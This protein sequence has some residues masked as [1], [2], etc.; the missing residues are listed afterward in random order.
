MTRKLWVGWAC[1]V[2]CFLGCA[3]APESREDQHSLE[4]QAEA[5]KTAMIRSDSSLQPLLASAAGYVIYP[6]V[7]EG[8]FVVGGTGGAG[9]VY[10]DGQPIGY[11]ELRGASVG[12]Q[13]GGQSYSQLVVFE[14]D[15]ALDRF[16]AGDFD[17][18][19]GLTATAVQSGAAAQAHF[20]DGTAVFINS[21][22]GLMAGATVGGQQMS[23]TAK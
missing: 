8:G 9:V 2:V 1:A 21:E 5:T 14:T 4:A 22:S 19:A 17:L 23:F 6:E 13:A 11:S 3:S 12:L 10:R 7:S 18:T 20:E 16:R 15:E